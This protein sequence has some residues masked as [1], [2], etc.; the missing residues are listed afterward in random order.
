LALTLMLKCNNPMK[1]ITFSIFLVLFLYPS[2]SQ[3]LANLDRKFGINKFK[4][5]SSI[6]L[7][8]SEITLQPYDREDDKVH[9]YKYTGGNINELFDVEISEISLGFYKDKL[10]QISYVFN[11]TT[12]Y[13][14]TI[15]YN[16]LKDLFGTPAIW[17]H[18]KLS[19]K[20]QWGHLWV[21]NKTYLD[22][23]KFDTLSDFKPNY[24]ELYMYSKKLRQQSNNEEF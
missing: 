4:L 7:Y 1:Q 22:Y 6:E 8:R 14:E 16:K 17:N 23:G 3:T 15:M 12:D 13:H 2:F 10:L 11:P 20:L 5:E 24:L 21:T 18:N 19:V 9:Y